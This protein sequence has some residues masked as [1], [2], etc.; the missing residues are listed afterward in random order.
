M[1]EAEYRS[2]LEKLSPSTLRD[3]IIDLW[4]ALDGES[5]DTPDDVKAQLVA[6]DKR[7]DELNCQKTALQQINADLELKVDRMRDVFTTVSNLL[8]SRRQEYAAIMHHDE[9]IVCS[10]LRSII[11]ELA[12]SV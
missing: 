10:Q 8:E 9:A 4:S 1:K 5:S 11:D 6:K 3:M 12:E 7:V 2:T